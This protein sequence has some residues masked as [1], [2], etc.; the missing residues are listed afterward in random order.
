MAL[1]S[2]GSARAP[3]Y[4]VALCQQKE[5]HRD[6]RTGS[7]LSPAGRTTYRWT[8]LPSLSLLTQVLPTGSPVALAIFQGGR[9]FLLEE[10]SEVIFVD[11]VG[12]K[13]LATL[14]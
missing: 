6:V 13:D 12:L 14:G 3:S 4:S 7:V 8:P 2:V 9:L 10:L 1:A 11:G 5:A